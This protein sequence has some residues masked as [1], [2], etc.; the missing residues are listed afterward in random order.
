MFS[1]SHLIGELQTRPLVQGFIIYIDYPQKKHKSICNLPMHPLRSESMGIGWSTIVNF[2]AVTTVLRERGD[3]GRTINIFLLIVYICAAHS[4]ISNLKFK[5]HFKT[6]RLKQSHF[7]LNEVE[8]MFQLIL[9]EDSCFFSLGRSSDGLTDVSFPKH[10]A[11][12]LRVPS[13]AHSQCLNSRA[14]M[15]ST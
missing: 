1:G 7:L 9:P 2:T 5:P 15:F 11:T 4:C 10:S 13:S 12:I 8:I 3:P 14:Q 6:I